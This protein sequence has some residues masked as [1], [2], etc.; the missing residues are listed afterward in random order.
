MYNKDSWFNVFRNVLSCAFGCAEPRTSYLFSLNDRW[1]PDVD[2]SLFL[3]AEK[4]PVLMKTCMF[5]SNDRWYPDV[6][7][8]FIGTLVLYTLHK[9]WLN[10]RWYPDDNDSSRLL[11]ERTHGRDNP[12]KVGLGDSDFLFNAHD[13]VPTGPKHINIKCSLSRGSCR[14]GRDDSIR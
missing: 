9:F 2:H 13:H 5:S 12:R 14:G 8:S 1:Y 6:T 4:A 3:S 7:R 11:P 10:D